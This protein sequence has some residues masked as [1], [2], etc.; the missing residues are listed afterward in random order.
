[1]N[2]GLKVVRVSKRIKKIPGGRGQG[3]V[4]GLVCS[5]KR[6]KEGCVAGEE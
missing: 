1:M 5:N 6:S 3:W 4:G 2:R